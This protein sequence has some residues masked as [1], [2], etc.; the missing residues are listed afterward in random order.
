MNDFFKTNAVRSIASGRE[1]SSTLRHEARA[2]TELTLNALNQTN[3]RHAALFLQFPP[4]CPSCRPAPVP[5][6]VISTESLLISKTQINYRAECVAT[7]YN[8]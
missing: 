1:A 5:N 4:L 6:R 2:F 8:P 7:E 3:V